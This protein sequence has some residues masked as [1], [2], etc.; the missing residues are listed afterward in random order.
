[1]QA[2]AGEPALLINHL[3]CDEGL[4]ASKA[5]RTDELPCKTDAANARIGQVQ[6]NNVFEA[7][8]WR[9]GCR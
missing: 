8:R 4:P 9:D 1:L 2:S 5:I 7:R 6:N 3:S